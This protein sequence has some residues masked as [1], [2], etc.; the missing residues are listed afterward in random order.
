MDGE[1]DPRHPRS[2]KGHTDYASS[3]VVRS[4][5]EQLQIYKFPL[6]PPPLEKYYFAGWDHNNLAGCSGMARNGVPIYPYKNTRG[7][8]V[9]S[10]CEADYCNAHSGKGEDYHYHGDPFGE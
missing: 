6:V 7:E 1:R 3:C 2:W 10:R 5:R 8:S 4:A 9:W